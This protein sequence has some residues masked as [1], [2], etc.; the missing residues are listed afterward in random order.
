MADDDKRISLSRECPGRAF[1]QT[2]SWRLRVSI[3][4]ALAFVSVVCLCGRHVHL[5]HTWCEDGRACSLCGYTSLL[6]LTG[7]PRQS[8][9]EQG[10]ILRCDFISSA[11]AA[12]F[13]LGFGSGLVVF[14]SV[15][16]WFDLSGGPNG[17]G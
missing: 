4:F 3:S 5:G 11:V 9:A 6:L 13:F 16:A 10:R 1:I 7:L 12:L 15:A 8:K 17:V 2:H 14:G